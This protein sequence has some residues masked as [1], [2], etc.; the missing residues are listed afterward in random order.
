VDLQ[1]GEAVAQDP[2]L[3]G[4]GGDADALLERGRQALEIAGALQQLEQALPRG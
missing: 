2:L 3:V 1:V 4:V